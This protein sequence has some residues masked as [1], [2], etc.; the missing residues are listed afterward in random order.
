MKRNICW[1]A[2][3][4]ALL[5]G[6]AAYAHDMYVIAVG[7]VGTRITSVPYTISSPGFYYLGSNLTH[8]GT[9]NGITINA[10]SVT[11]DLMG[12]SLAGPG[13]TSGTG[14]IYI[15]PG[16][17][18]VEVRNGSVKSF[19]AGIWSDVGAGNGNCRFANLRLSGC[20]YGIADNNIGTIITGCQANNNTVCGF[21]CRGTG[22][23]L[24]KNTATNNNTGFLAGGGIVTNNLA[25][26]NV[27]GFSLS[28]DRFQLVDRNAS[29]DNTTTNWFGLTGCTVGLNTP[30]N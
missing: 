17:S 18:E 6:Q 12:F 30:L 24:D 23:I 20:S 28:G 26:L 15:Q 7:S 27:T 16:M 13:P 2:L 29:S 25:R 4:A 3:V 10:N 14:G 11:L 9:T 22:G 19:Y 1:L 21:Y 8:T 5:W